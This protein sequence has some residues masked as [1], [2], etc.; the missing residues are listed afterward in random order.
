MSH[1]KRLNDAVEDGLTAFWKSVCENYSEAR[2]GDID[3]WVSHV[4]ETAAQ[5]AVINWVGNNVTTPKDY[6]E[7]DKT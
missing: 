4:L 7:G 6:A 2:S 5:E 3:P 1:L